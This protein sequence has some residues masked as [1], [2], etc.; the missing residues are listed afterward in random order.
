MQLLTVEEEFNVLIFPD[1]VPLIELIEV[2]FEEVP[3]TV[4]I[5]TE[6][7]VD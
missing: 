3:D 2:D 5:L 4:L 7:S 6:F 1:E